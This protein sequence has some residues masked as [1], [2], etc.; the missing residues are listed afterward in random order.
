MKA[1]EIVLIEYSV[2]EGLTKAPGVTM[3]TSPHFFASQRRCP[4][5][6]HL[7]STNGEGRFKCHFCPFNDT[8]NVSKL[9]KAGL[10]YDPPPS[11][12]IFYGKYNPN[13]H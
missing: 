10:D 9:L 6:G 2:R 11:R 12:P 7:L 4:K 3:T 5:C 13:A 1:R 8:Q